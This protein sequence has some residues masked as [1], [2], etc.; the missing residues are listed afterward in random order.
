MSAFNKEVKATR[1]IDVRYNQATGMLCIELIDGQVHCYR[2]QELQGLENATAAD[3]A[4][5]E[6][7]PFGRGIHF[8]T[9]DA[10]LW[11]PG[12]LQGRTGSLAWMRRNT[13]PHPG[14]V[15]SEYLEG[16][17]MDEA[18][19]KLGVDRATVERIVS[20]D[21]EISLD[22]AKRLGAALGTS[23]EL[24]LGLQAQRDGLTLKFT[25]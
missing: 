12:L 21:L 7:S 19:L 24:W 14:E 6:I 1:A 10:D 22:L 20:G 8:P 5:Y 4:Q 23:E 18:A 11:I 16:L 3:L 2:P 9:I 17:S 25:S 13:P 15:L